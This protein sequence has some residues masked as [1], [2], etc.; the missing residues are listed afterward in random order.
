MEN[1]RNCETVSENY[2]YWY[3]KQ[4]KILYSISAINFEFA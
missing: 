4:V 2:F 1:D 3:I